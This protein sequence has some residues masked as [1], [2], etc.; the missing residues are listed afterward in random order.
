MS[1]RKL[2]IIGAGSGFTAGLVADLLISD[3]ADEWEVGLV[4]IDERALEIAQGLVQRMV[5]FKQAPV[6]VQASTDRCDVLAGAD[7]VV[8]TI[9]VGGRRGWENDVVVPQKHGVF[10]PVGDTTSAGGLS[11]ALRMVPP[12]LDIAQDVLRL[13]P[14]AYFFNYANP[15]AAICRA[16]TKATEARLTG[17]CHGVQGTVRHLCALVDVPYSEVTALYFGMNHLT[18]ITHLTRGGEDLWPAVRAKLAETPP[19]DNPFSWE[20]F[21]TYGAFPAVLDRHVCEFFPQN[22]GPGSY[23]GKTMSEAFDILGCI[24]GGDARY[25]RMADQAV[26]KV[27]LED[28][29]FERTLGEHE[30]FIPILA[31]LFADRQGIFPMNVPNRCMAGI[32]AGFVVEQP[33]IASAAGCLQVALPPLT[34]GQLA[35]I[36]EALYGVE[37]IVDAALAGSKDLFIEALLYDGCVT[38]R[39]AAVAL[40]EDLLASQAQY[41]PRFA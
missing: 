28:S 17:L 15:M 37:I 3:I 41:L 18:W 23:Y 25:E 2:A 1:K 5:D 34:S 31:S 6:T 20:L 27:P 40:A 16:V 32:P 24:H 4:D 9:S 12:M 30:A 19:T 39:L 22:V 10:Q 35:I 36:S 29:L 14:Q 11:R 7:A 21:E 13:C 33:V 38:N 26:G 8:T